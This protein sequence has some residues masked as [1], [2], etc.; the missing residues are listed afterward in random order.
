MKLIGFRIRDGGA[1]D[2]LRCDG[3]DLKNGHIHSLYGRSGGG[4]SLTLEAC[5][6][7]FHETNPACRL[8][9]N[10]HSGDLASC[11]KS[12]LPQNVYTHVHALSPLREQMAGC[13][14]SGTQAACS[15]SDWI[16][17][18]AGRALGLGNLSHESRPGQ[19]SGGMLQRY[20]L[21][22]AVLRCPRLLLLD[23]PVSH[24]DPIN[25]LIVY[26]LI[27]DFCRKSGAI[28]L[29][30]GHD[31][32]LASVFDGAPLK[33]EFGLLHES[34][35][36]EIEQK[37]PL[38][39]RL[40]GH[41]PSKAAII[42][43][44]LTIGYSTGFNYKTILRDISHSFEIPGIYGLIGPSGCGKTTLLNALAGRLPML[45]G[46]IEAPIL[47]KHGRMPRR[48]RCAVLQYI[49]QDSYKQMLSTTSL[50]EALNEPLRFYG[51][52]AQSDQE[53]T[54]ELNQVGLDLSLDRRVGS[55]SYG[56]KQ[57]LLLVRTLRGYPDLRV[58]LL[59]EPLSGL[60]SDAR[61]LTANYL[62][63]RKTN[64]LIIVASHETDVLDGL[65]DKILFIDDGAI[66]EV[67]TARPHAFST[68][69]ARYYWEAGTLWGKESVGEW[70]TRAPHDIE[71]MQDTFDGIDAILSHLK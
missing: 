69:Q 60:D 36:V 46:T 12:W 6:G 53:W 32:R 50:R 33:V 70:M 40:S 11:R 17:D 55:L 64:L 18:T 58:L 66:K 47:P 42:L 68:V 51:R 9:W 16:L 8:T 45:D 5:T 56:E 48:T 29:W 57:R 13:L 43:D 30:A 52:A 3:V 22:L 25:R 49:E 26:R 34:T 21:A 39:T 24:L 71:G 20:L 4:K 35:S 19:F 67:S 10:E 59:D 61:V 23:E 1:N 7:F 2:L 62:I 63:R 38:N 37:N 27:S 14:S 44:G 15:S 28:A 31:R 65:C 54:A 41:T